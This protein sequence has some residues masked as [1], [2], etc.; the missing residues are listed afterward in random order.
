MPRI[1]VVWARI[2]FVPRISQCPSLPRKDL[3]VYNLATAMIER[4]RNPDFATHCCD[5][6]GVKERTD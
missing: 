5:L 6:K 1:G 4:E 3:H 2:G